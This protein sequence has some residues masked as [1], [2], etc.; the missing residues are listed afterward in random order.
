MG[1]STSKQHDQSPP[2]AEQPTSTQSGQETGAQLTESA[3]SSESESKC[4]M[5][6]K[7]GSGYS[8]DWTQLF[9]AAA[10]HGPTG[11]KPLSQEEQEK[12]RQ[13]MKEG[14]NAIIDTPSEGG[15]PVKYSGGKTGPQYPEYNVYSEPID[16]T[17][18]MPKGIK[19]Q[20]PTST[21]TAELSTDRVK[22]S[23][24][25]GGGDSSETTAAAT[26]TTWTYP[27]P[28]QFYNAL[29]RK[30]KLEDGTTEDDMASV[31]ALHNNM[32]EKTWAKVVEWER[33]T[34]KADA[35]PK[36]LKFMGRPHDLS[37]KA[38]LKHWVF[39]HPLPY[40]RHDWT[41]LRDDGTTIRYTIDYYYDDTRAQT[42]E[43]SSM[44][45]LHDRDA[46]PSLL[47]DVRPALDGP[48]QL[49][50]RA[51]QM[52]YAI[53]TKESNYEPLPLRGTPEMASQVQESIQ[54]WKAMQ[55]Q[56][57]KEQ[58]Q[59]QSAHDIV[60]DISEDQAKAIALN[61]AQAMK[62]CTQAQKRIANCQS[63]EECSKA[64]VDLTMCMGQHL[65]IVQHKNLV[66]TLNTSDD[67]DDAKI[68]AALET[69]TECVMHRTAERRHA[70][71][72]HPSLFK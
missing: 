26:T 36:L 7:D 37:P 6:K 69:L 40:D 50:A 44:P 33:Q 46:T 18:Q 70:R 57:R 35:T 12:A 42:T 67:A 49:V 2:L 72:Q 59:Q 48:G 13:A 64:S 32:N 41:V 38:R 24:P 63:E 29:A 61:F 43:E 4:P 39:G 45:Q 1:A 20:M 3:D 53:W 55:E 58:Q 15:C 8:Y 11:N 17:N 66:Q 28:Q 9:K 27:S 62:A 60:M 14:K 25:K 34:Y 56:S 71:E 23:I 68:E 51:V 19:T 65:C 10:V 22:S 21:Q 54:V 52:P 31:V 5:H 16:K 30:G 47:V